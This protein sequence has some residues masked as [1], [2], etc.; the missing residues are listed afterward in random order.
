M[1]SLANLVRQGE[2]T[3]YSVFFGDNGADMPLDRPEYAIPKNPLEFDPRRLMNGFHGQFVLPKEMVV[4]ND[5][6]QL[7]LDNF[8]ILGEPNLTP[9]DELKAILF[10]MTPSLRLRAKVQLIDKK[11]GNVVDKKVTTL[12]KIPRLSGFRTVIVNGTEYAIV[13]QLRLRPGVYL[14]RRESGESE[15]HINVLPHEGPSFRIVLDPEEGIFHLKVSTTTIPLYSFLNFLGVSDDEIRSVL[16]PRLYAANKRVANVQR[17]IVKF[18]NKL[19]GTKFKEVTPELRDLLFE[20]LQR[21]S[22]DSGVNRLT[23]GRDRVYNLGDPKLFLDIAARLIKLERGEIPTFDRDNIAFQRVYSFEDLLMD[24]IRLDPDRM[25]NRALWM[26]TSAGKLKGI[27]SNFFQ[28]YV[29]ALIYSTGLGQTLEG[30]NPLE[31]LDQVYRVTRLGEGGIPSVD[32]VPDEARMVHPSHLGFIDPVRTPDSSRVGVDLRFSYLSVKGPDNQ[33]YTPL[34][35]AKTGKIS[36]YSARELSDKTIGFPGSALESEG[37][38]WVPAIRSG[39]MEYVR[40]EEVDLYPVNFEASFSPLSNLVPLKSAMRAHRAAM[41]ARMLTQA[42]PLEKGEAPFVRNAVPDTNEKLSFEDF[43]SN[44]VGVVRAPEDAVVSEVGKTY[45]KLKT[46][47]GNEYTL[48]Y[49]P[50]RPFNRITYISQRPVVKVGDRVKKGQPVISSNFAQDDGAIA[51]GRNLRVL[52]LPYRGLNHEDAIVISESAAKKLASTHL[53]D[54]DIEPDD[55]TFIDKKRFLSIFPKK[56][57]RDQLEKITDEGF[58]KPGSIVQKG[59]PLML[60]LRKQDFGK[61]KAFRGKSFTM[62]DASI[63]WDHDTP[64][65][66]LDVVKTPYGYAV[67][68]KTV[69]PVQ[70]GDKITD[71]FGSKGIV[72]AIIPDEL[73]PRDREGKPFEVIMNPLAVM[74]RVNPA[75]LIEAALGKIA[76]KRGKPYFVEDWRPDRDLTRWAL[77]EMAKHGIPENEDVYDPVA[78]RVIRNVFTGNKF[79]MKLSHMA[80]HKEQERFSGGYT[81]EL[82]PS[83][84]GE[85]AAKR[86][87]LQEITALLSH[88]AYNVLRDFRLVKSQYNPDLWFSFMTGGPIPPQKEPFVYQKFLSYLRAAG[89]NPVRRG[90]RMYLMALTDEDI[91]NLSEGRTIKRPETVHWETLN[92][93][94]DG[95]F[96]P[97]LVGDANNPRWAKI[98]LPTGVINPVFEDAVRI[99]LGVTAKELDDIYLGRKELD[100]K[101][102]PEAIEDALKKIS[103][104][105]DHEIEEA[106]RIARTSRGQKRDIAIRKLKLLRAAKNTGVLPHKWIIHKIPVVPPSM[107]PVSTLGDDVTIVSDLNLLYQEIINQADAYRMVSEITDDLEDERKLLRDAVRALVGT[108]APHSKRLQRKNVKGVIRQLLG[109][110]PKFGHFQRKLL[111]MNV[112]LVGRAVIAPNADLDIDEIGVPEDMLWEL[113]KPFVIR[114]LRRRGMRLAEAVEA[115][116]NRTEPARRALDEERKERP[117][118]ANRS[119]VLHRYGIM[120]HWAVPVKGHVIQLPPQVLAG[121][122]ADFDG[123]QMNIHVPVLPEAVEEAKRRMLPSRNFIHVADFDVH[124]LPRHEFL[125]GLYAADKRKSGRFAGKFKDIRQVID[126]YQSGRLDIWDEV[127]VESG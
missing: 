20:R 49:A 127:E 46:D 95:L 120:A 56:Y 121:F 9:I 38:V 91:D 66:V 82:E 109:D 102:G 36:Y 84:G 99:L 122:G 126:A 14:R 67:Y 87:G 4:E 77:E 7:K 108:M 5:R 113:F 62:T 45:I 12:A 41:G 93:I 106:E 124:Q 6:Y 88:G 92:P 31:F 28:P 60:V 103:D 112:D 75:G 55:R 44:A 116:K 50:M 85:A 98:E 94:K 3:R 58:V 78:N 22:Q 23:V 76:E 64:G 68:V 27:G 33:I 105:I 90:N 61:R 73:M 74:S 21:I 110:S 51:L 57:S 10:K 70:I 115:W 83:K 43:Y 71:R 119:P 80:E 26:S 114:R 25:L 8:Q 13:N 125:V 52:F 54:Y 48:P 79:I 123:D 29:D 81:S 32:A 24:R 16:G 30:I 11:T 1:G 59:D 39:K 111:G 35:S 40:P 15:A 86:I 65:E 17:D 34:R 97:T 101:S 100:G 118:I 53:Y 107:R 18:A 19:M 69:A 42:L 117:V 37:Q 104:N 89:I 47:S 63:E 2:K 96:D 72:S